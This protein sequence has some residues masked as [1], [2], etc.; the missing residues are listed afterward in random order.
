MWLVSGQAAWGAEPSRQ[1]NAAPEVP[2]RGRPP[3]QLFT[4]C[5]KSLFPGGSRTVIDTP[6]ILL[7]PLAAV[8]V[9]AY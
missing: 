9:L 8:I 5:G 3:P 1:G 4:R 6:P 2:V 7:V